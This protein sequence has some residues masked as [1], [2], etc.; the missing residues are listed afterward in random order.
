[1]KP[2]ILQ[3]SQGATTKNPLWREILE[4]SKNKYLLAFLLS[5]IALSGL[6]IP[7]IPGFFIFIIALALL[8][9]GWMA[10]IRRRVRLWKI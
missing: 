5:L 3:K 1:M 9:K 2:F 8:R 10:R 6:L 4:F 7:I